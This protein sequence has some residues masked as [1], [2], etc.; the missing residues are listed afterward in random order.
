MLITAQYDFLPIILSMGIAQVGPY[1]SK[2][3]C[4]DRRM[5]LALA[6]NNDLLANRFALK[7]WRAALTTTLHEAFSRR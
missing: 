4:K 6:P 2:V 3:A 5:K 7:V 1:L